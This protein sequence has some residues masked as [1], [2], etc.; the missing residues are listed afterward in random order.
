MSIISFKGFSYAGKIVKVPII[1]CFLARNA[2]IK[3]EVQDVDIVT[4]TVENTLSEKEVKAICDKSRLN[5]GH[6][7]LVNGRLPYDEPVH[8]YHNTVKYK[9]RMYGRYGDVSNVY[10]GLAWP[11]AE[12]LEDIREY[13]SL[14]YPFTIQEMQ[15]NAMKIIECE[16]QEI[17][18]NQQKIDNNMK[19]LNGWLNEVKEKATKKLLEA[20]QAKEKKEKLIEEVKKHFGYKIDP[21]DDRFKE[22]LVKR[23]KE[24]KK[25]VREEKK[26][27]REE[28]LLNYLDSKAK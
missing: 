14:A 8:R 2:S 3:N 20:Q 28:K 15:Q 16:R 18:L 25:K 1:Q 4:T 24:E 7:N 13:E 9:R 21:K 10:P 19:K 11:T 12:D 5:R 26:K 17:Q 27:I 23:E 6:R 22:M